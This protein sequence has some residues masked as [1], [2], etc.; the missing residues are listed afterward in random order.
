[1]LVSGALIT[2]FVL[3]GPR[4]PTL[5]SCSQEMETPQAE[6]PCFSTIPTQRCCYCLWLP[7]L[8][9]GGACGPSMGATATVCNVWQ[10]VAL[11]RC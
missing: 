1:M 10:W 11:E 3:P 5:S 6:S 9:C 4:R 2:V 8:R 7:I